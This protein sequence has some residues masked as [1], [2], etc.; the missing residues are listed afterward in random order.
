MDLVRSTLLQTGHLLTLVK[1]S[2]EFAQKWLNVSREIQE[3]LKRNSTQ[4]TLKTL[5]RY[6]NKYPYLLRDWITNLSNYKYQNQP[7]MKRIVTHNETIIRYVN[8]SQEKLKAIIDDLLLDNSGSSKLIQRMKFIDRSANMW[9]ALLEPIKLD[10]FYGFP[11]EKALSDY[12]KNV[13]KQVSFN[14][15]VY[16]GS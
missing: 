1:R 6:S 2:K 16:S 12:Y 13:S 4:N 14:K 9:I 15:H 3:T 7:Y 10:I 8:Q 11:T 5:L